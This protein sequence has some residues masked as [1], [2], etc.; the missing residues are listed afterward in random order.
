MRSR[1]PLRASARSEPP[2]PS[3]ESATEPLEAR[4]ILPEKSTAGIRPCRKKWTLE[5]SSPKCRFSAK[6]ASVAAWF[7]WLVMM[8]QWSGRPKRLPAA[9]SFSAK[10]WKSERCLTGVTGNV[11]FGPS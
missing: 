4:R 11:P 1:A 5:R 9:V 7:W 10:T 6:K 2:C 8:N 3:G